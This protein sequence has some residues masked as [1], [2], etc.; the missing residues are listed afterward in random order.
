MVGLHGEVPSLFTAS[1]RNKKRRPLS[2][3]STEHLSRFKVLGLYGEEMGKGM[4]VGVKN[5]VKEVIEKEM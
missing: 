1:N 4:S 2:R 3:S 5:R